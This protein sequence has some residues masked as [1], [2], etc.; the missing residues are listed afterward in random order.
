MVTVDQARYLNLN[1]IGMLKEGNFADFII[2]YGS[3]IDDIRYQLGK[4]LI[5]SIYKRGVRVVDNH[6]PK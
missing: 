4:N 5:H 1:K 6:R 3:D 2:F